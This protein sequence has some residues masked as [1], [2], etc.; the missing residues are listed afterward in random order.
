[1]EN[2]SQITVLQDAS[3]NGRGEV[4]RFIAS[5]PEGSESVTISRSSAL[6]ERL[7]LV[8]A[9]V[10]A[11]LAL[12]EAV[13]AAMFAARQALT[14]VGV[15]KEALGILDQT[16]DASRTRPPAQPNREA[17]TLLS[18]REREVLAL[19]AEGHT[20]KSIAEGSLPVAQH[21]Q[22]PYRLAAQQ[23]ARA[24][25]RR[26]GSDRGTTGVSLRAYRG[27]LRWTECEACADCSTRCDS[28]AR[29]LPS[30]RLAASCGS[31]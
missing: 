31:S 18:P 21:N 14:Y 2:G 19:V 6:P 9:T 27:R 8:Q 16:A 17:I 4:A 10:E 3:G 20:N 1:M 15:I 11:R 24:H 25:P 5:T 12:E 28:P 23:A 22:E 7:E 29:S 13:A 26:V 30:G